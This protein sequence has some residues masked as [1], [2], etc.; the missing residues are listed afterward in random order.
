MQ[1]LFAWFTGSNGHMF[2]W[3]DGRNLSPLINFSPLASFQEEGSV[4]VVS[5]FHRGW[6]KNISVIKRIFQHTPRTGIVLGGPAYC[7]HSQYG[8]SYNKTPLLRKYLHYKESLSFHSS[9]L[10]LF[11][12]FDSFHILR[13]EPERLRTLSTFSLVKRRLWGVPNGSLAIAIK[14]VEKMEPSFS[15]QYI[16]EGQ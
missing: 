11:I 6:K 7:G 9:W 1:Y 14:S 8:N 4:M 2:L 5:Q 13:R 3:K 10:R 15:Q 16:A 12:F